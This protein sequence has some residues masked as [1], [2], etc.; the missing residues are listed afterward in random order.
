MNPL[1]FKAHPL[2]ARWIDLITHPTAQN[3]SDLLYLLGMLLAT[4]LLWAAGLPWLLRKAEGLTLTPLKAYL[5]ALPATLLYAPLMLTLLQDVIGHSFEFRNRFFLLFALVVGSQLL[6]ALYAFTLR[7]ERSG[8]PIGIES[9]LSV[10]LFLLLAS[11]PACL[12]LMGIHALRPI[13]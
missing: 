10:S 9:G 5:A 6:T 13:F 1:L 11:I 12:L 3:L 8:A 4:N 7:H 2:L